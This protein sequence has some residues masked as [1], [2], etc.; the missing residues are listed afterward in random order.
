MEK[1][2]IRGLAHISSWILGAWGGLVTLKA[3]YDLFWGEPEAN[4]YAPKKWAFVTQ[5]QWMRYAGFELAYGLALL[6]LAWYLVKLGRLL[7]VTVS[8]PKRGPEFSLF[9]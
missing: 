1:I 3:F 8:R 5:E 6:A 2:K 4:L 9:D 7:P